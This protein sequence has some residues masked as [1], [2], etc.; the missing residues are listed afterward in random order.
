MILQMAQ[1]IPILWDTTGSASDFGSPQGRLI[2]YTSRF[3]AK[4]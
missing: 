3:V 2:A 4:H 1:H